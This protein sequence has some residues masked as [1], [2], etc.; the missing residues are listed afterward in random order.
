M[1]QKKPPKLTLTAARASRVQDSLDVLVD[2]R[3]P[4]AAALIRA[5]PED[6]ARM[7]LFAAVTSVDPRWKF[8]PNAH[9]QEVAA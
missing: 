1:T 3:S 5:L 8:P 7:L 6:D 4:R 9:T 2:A